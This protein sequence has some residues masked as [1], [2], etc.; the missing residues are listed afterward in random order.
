[1]RSSDLAIPISSCKIR[2]HDVR[3]N[4]HPDYGDGGDDYASFF[5]RKIIIVQIKIFLKNIY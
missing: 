1:M 4:F 2:G 3:V 5:I